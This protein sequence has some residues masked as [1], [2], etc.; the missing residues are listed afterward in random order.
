MVKE[1][2]E[3]AEGLGRI[4]QANFR[5]PRNFGVEAELNYTSPLPLMLKSDVPDYNCL[6]CYP[7]VLTNCNYFYDF[8]RK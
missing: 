2:I 4:F 8:Q 3:K 7:E 5:R 1:I 6:E